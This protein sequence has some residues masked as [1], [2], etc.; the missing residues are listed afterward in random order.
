MISPTFLAFI[1][2]VCGSLRKTIQLP[3]DEFR[4]ASSS[5]AFRIKAFI[6]HNDRQDA[7]HQ[8]D[9]HT[10]VLTWHIELPFPIHL[11]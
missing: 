8:E 11:T 4:P 5:T 6:D 1:N 7:Q 10:P 2:P 9:K 3:L